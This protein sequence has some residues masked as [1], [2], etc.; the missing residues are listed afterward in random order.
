MPETVTVTNPSRTPAR[1]QNTY[2]T[3]FGV[4]RWV[5]LFAASTA[6]GVG[7][8][9][10][11]DTGVTAM[12]GA[13]FELGVG[14]AAMIGDEKL[15][16]RFEGVTSD[17]RCGKGETCVWEGDATVTVVVRLAGAADEQHALHTSTRFPDSVMYRGYSIRLALLS[18]APAAGDTPAQADYRAAFEVTRGASG[19]ENVL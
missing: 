12:L 1:S 3:A 17:S 6:V 13:P 8:A 18:P 15:E 16:V 19:R 10:E 5:L 7:C 2:R 9:A 14:Q 11:P 4:R